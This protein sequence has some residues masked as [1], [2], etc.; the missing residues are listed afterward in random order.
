MSLIANARQPEDPGHAFAA[1]ASLLP[2]AGPVLT[3]A[4]IALPQVSAAF[5]RLALLAPLEKPMLVK[6]CFAIAFVDG[7]SH[8]RAASCLRT[9]CAA[10]DCPLPPQ[11]E[12]AEA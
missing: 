9:L 7:H 12:V 3:H 5:D 10:L 2:A 8:W 4:Q 1:A 6:A 11:V